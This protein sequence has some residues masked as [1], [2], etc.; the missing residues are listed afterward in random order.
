[1]LAHSI[2]FDPVQPEAAFSALPQQAGVFALFGASAEAE[3]YISRTPNLHRRLRRFLGASPA[4][5][6]RLQL[7]Q[8]IARIEWSVAGSD[9]EALLL[10]YR[11]SLEAF[12]QQAR[13]RLH[14]RAPALLRMST[15][16]DY[17]R[18]YVTNKVTF[19]AA[20]DLFGPFPSRGAAEKFLDEMLNLFHLRRCHED[21]HPDP[22]F[23]GCIYSEMKMCLAPCFKGCTDERYA[24]ETAAV[25]AFL[26]TRGDSLIRSVSAERDAASQ[27]LAFEKAA[28]AHAKLQKIEAVAAL[29]SPAVHALD[30]LKGAIVQ[31]SAE[32][33][34]VALFLLSRGC[35]FGPVTYSVAG[36][37]HPNEQS[38]SSSLFAHPV[39][40]EAVPLAENSSPVETASRDVLEQR[41]EQ[42]LTALRLEEMATRQNPQ[43]I[44]DQLCIFSR[45][46]YRPQ[47]RRIGEVA[48]AGDDGVLQKKAV[49]R[50]ISRVFRAST[51][52]G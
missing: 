34:G 25:R 39:A 6:R 29:A 52:D 14:L 24:E 33:D 19:S 26:Q 20:H 37:R 51:H 22:V 49:L 38:G 8:K 4:Q 46:Y 1:M 11:A 10:L 50:A 17:P 47:T 48:F 13:K 42:A 40:I 18:V 45:W 28:D 27:A 9:F 23:P 16:N 31:P 3:P 35:I 36:M 44:A 7:A 41:L 15:Q 5:S 32:P 30:E 21:L 12:G 2:P 43:Q